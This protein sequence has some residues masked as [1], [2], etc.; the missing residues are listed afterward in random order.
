[1]VVL[2]EPGINTNQCGSGLTQFI[3]SMTG[4]G[5]SGASQH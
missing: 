4:I 5:A 3:R 1:M 2:N